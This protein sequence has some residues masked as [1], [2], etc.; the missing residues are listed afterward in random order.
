MPRQAR[1]AIGDTVYHVLNRGNGRQTIFHHEQ[2][3]LDFE[4]LLIEAK[5]LIGM[6]ILAY[7]LMQNHF[8]LVL[9]PHHDGDLSE[10]MRWLTTTHVRKYR[11]A[12]KSIGHGHLYQGAYKSFPIEAD[13]HLT[14]VIRYVEQNPLRTKLVKRAEDWKWGSLHRR[15]SGTPKE[16]KLLSALPTKLPV[17][18]L[19]SVN[20]IYNDD[21]LTTL[22]T[23]VQKGVPY[24]DERWMARFTRKNIT[25]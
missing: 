9:Y 20:T 2:D 25:P 1:V 4:A 3:Y 5:E 6:R 23:S 18:Y 11:V 22:R 14:T 8:H 19:D 21:M 13:Q 16:R 12:T 7:T 24:G 17:Q 10:F 15:V